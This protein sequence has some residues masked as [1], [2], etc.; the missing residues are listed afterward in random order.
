M[1]KPDRTL[2]KL[3]DYVLEKKPGG[4]TD[5][6]VEKN[7]GGGAHYAVEKKFGGDGNGFDYVLEEA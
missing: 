7:P 6:A 1:K 3:K 5:C 2:P 4:G